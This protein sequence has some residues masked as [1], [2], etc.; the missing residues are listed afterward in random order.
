MPRQSKASKAKAAASAAASAAPK[1]AAPNP[2]GAVAAAAPVRAAVRRPAADVAAEEE[3]NE[4]AD[5][6]N[7]QEEDVDGEDQEGDGD[8]HEADAAA[9]AEEVAV[10]EAEEEAVEQNCAKEVAAMESLLA[11]WKATR[12]AA[13]KKDQSVERVKTG[14]LSARTV[15]DVRELWEAAKVALERHIAY[16]PLLLLKA[17]SVQNAAVCESTTAE[18]VAMQDQGTSGHNQCVNGIAKWTLGSGFA[19][20]S[21][22]QARETGV[23]AVGDDR[24]CVSDAVW[25]GLSRLGMS[26]TLVAVRRDLTMPDED[27]KVASVVTYCR[28]LGVEL[29]WHGRLAGSERGLFAQREGIFLLSLL[30]TGDTKGELWSENHMIC[31]DARNR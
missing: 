14:N 4:K 20:L 24:T 7:N 27:T 8:Q 10:Q 30:M 31:F 1:P 12:A 22:T 5:G 17:Q 28:A 9:E 3:G 25:V 15:N 11:N 29:V 21:R 23:V 2:R 26:L 6:D 13:L 16:L 19:L 18:I